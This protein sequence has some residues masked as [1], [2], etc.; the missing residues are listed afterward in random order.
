MGLCNIG[1]SCLCPGSLCLVFGLHEHAARVPHE[2]ILV[3]LLCKI[4]LVFSP[5]CYIYIY[6]LPVYA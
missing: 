2:Y 3:Y 1:Q 4:M 5:T 6:K